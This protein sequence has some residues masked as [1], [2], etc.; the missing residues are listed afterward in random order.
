MT[1]PE[2]IAKGF[3]EALAKP[4][5]S[6][7]PKDSGQR[8]TTLDELLKRLKLVRD[9]SINARGGIDEL[10]RVMNS[11]GGDIKI[12]KGINQQLR[13]QGINKD[14]LDFISD[15][16]PA[17]QK[18]FIT[19]K[20]GIVSITADGKKLAKA[21]NEAVLG[22]LED[23]YKNQIQ[24]LRAQSA[25]FTELRAAGLSAAEALEIVT[26][27][28][29]ALAFASGKSKEEIDK[30]IAGLRELR[31]NEKRTQD[32]INP[33]ERI[34]K[35]VSMAMEYFDVLEREA[36]NIYEP[37]IEAVNK[38]ID[39][40]EKLIDEEQ[41]KIDLNIDRPIAL[42]NA[43][44]KILNHD[45]SLI[46]KAAESINK[47]YDEQEKALQQISDI[48]DEI[49]DKEK[50]RITI[51]D[52]LT[53]GDISAAAKAI[54]EE[55][56]AA[57]QRALERSSNLLQVAREKELGKLTN[58][59]G[60]T[61]IQIEEKLYTISEEIY[62]IEQKE[63]PLRNEILR[64]QEK[65]YEINKLQ[66]LPL[67]NKLKL[68]LDAI[69]AQK[70][71]WDAVALGVDGARVRGDEYQTVLRNHEA[72]LIRMKALWDGITS[73]ELG[74]TSLTTFANP[75]AETD[76]EKSARILKESQDS[77]S[78]SKAQ[79]EDLTNIIKDINN[80]TKTKI[81]DSK[82]K[83]TVVP[84]LSGGLYGPTPVMPTKTPTQTPTASAS[85]PRG[86]GYYFVPPTKT[87]STVSY[88]ARAMGGIIPKYYVSGGYSK[89]TDTIPAMLTPGEFVV[90]KNAVD[91]FGV[92]NLNKINDGS[93]GGSSVYNYSLNVNVKS[94][95][96][97][98][99]IARTVM[100]QIKRIDNQRIK[101]QRG[102]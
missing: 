33:A 26:N 40:N 46:D 59:N 37:Q 90:R 72:T 77:L 28:Q 12:F 2:Y 65:N 42:L 88:R 62:A 8:D 6:T 7:E 44:S 38:L 71:K 22:E 3:N 83:I 34:K 10:R 63:I 43:Q 70:D 55:R 32:I 91:S 84:P 14:L 11:T 47:K 39:A 85:G 94:D 89:G 30:I 82:P 73:K 93:Y 78:E 53:R 21:L 101:T 19:I 81:S 98:D 92:N 52:A 68:E 49:A 67:Q 13:A 57:A 29:V 99:D 79:L 23:S 35:E 96:S 95:S 15:L 27:E 87:S 80:S 4:T 31:R 58:S 74:A 100:T 17:I 36:K 41:R 69:Q 16:D 51:A 64:L 9:A 1:V 48:Q 66:L 24:G 75:A 61:R 60:L 50:G 20:K 97:P 5:I 86:G 45:L 102:A 56:Q 76:A 18:K 54:Q 25:K